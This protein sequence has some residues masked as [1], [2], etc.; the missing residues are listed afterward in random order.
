MRE[1]AFWE[2]SEEY[3]SIHLFFWLLTSGIAAAVL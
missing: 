1:E 3:F 2:I